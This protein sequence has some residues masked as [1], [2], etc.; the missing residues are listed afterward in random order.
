MPILDMDALFTALSIRESNPFAFVFGD[1]VSGYYEGTTKTEKNPPKYRQGKRWIFADF[2][3]TSNGTKINKSEAQYAT[4][5]PYGIEH[6]YENGISDCLSLLSGEETLAIHI[7]SSTIAY[8]GFLPNLNTTAGTIQI[9]DVKDKSV[10]LCFHP[11][12]NRFSAQYMTLSADKEIQVIEQKE[13]K[14]S[15]IKVESLQ[16]EQSLT[17][18]VSFAND[19]NTSINLS[20][21]GHK[22]DKINV[23]KNQLYRFL[24]KN[25]LWTNDLDYNRAVM[26]SRLASRTFVNKEYGEGIWA[27]LP[28][29]KDCWGRDTF[30]ALSGTSL[31]NG[32][33]DEA[34]SIIKNFANMQ[35][36]RSESIHLGR[37][38]NRVTNK[39]HVIYNTTDG[40]PWMMREIIEYVNYS[41]DSDFAKQM[42][43]TLKLYIDGV[44]KHYLDENGLMT[45]REPDTWMDAKIEGQIPWSP[46]GNRA[47]DIQALWYTSLLSAIEIAKLQNDKMSENKWKALAQKTKKSVTTLFWDH[48]QNCVAD[49]ISKTGVASKQVRPNQLMA[50]TIPFDNDLVTDPIGAHILKNAVSTLLFPWGICSLE[51]DDDHFHPFHDNH[52]K[53]NKD[54]AYHNGTIWGW[55]AGFTINALTLFGKQEL[56]Y[57]FSLNLAKQILQQGHRGTM[58]EN[59]DAFQHN[60]DKLVESGTYAQ[61]W[62]VSEFARNAQQHY[63]GFKPELLKNIITLSPAFPL[64]WHD[65]YARVPFGQSSSLHIKYQRVGNKQ[66]FHLKYIGSDTLTL[67]FSMRDERNQLWQSLLPLESTLKL[68]FDDT[69][70]KLIANRHRVIP[71][72]KIASNHSILDDL[73]FAS[74]N[75]EIDPKSI[76]VD[77]YLQDIITSNNPTVAKDSE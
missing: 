45:H 77:H 48:K 64:C 30:I 33:F 10:C 66:H 29:F 62:S 51:Q 44:L 25:Y 56:A 5:L 55:N 18:Y 23:H 71:M 61:A 19:K 74:P 53:Y 34:K 35:M 2:T 9:V 28:W 3:V 13:N 21:S 58:S 75:C 63:L 50:I 22:N 7:K 16:A 31:I 41:G 26:W 72:I 40:T 39:N 68:E 57:K 49:H 36:T 60:P 67:C 38:P 4:L 65:L 43:P 46:R 8:I 24:T 54:A 32:L 17:L 20:L 15:P 69:T 12:E 6:Q 59:L 1:N 52:P 42:Y 14:T 27:G 47:V 76:N 37:I 11:K 73:D 70:A